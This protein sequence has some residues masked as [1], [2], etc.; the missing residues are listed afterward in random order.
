LF[1]VNG[2]G[3]VDPDVA[4]AAAKK[5]AKPKKLTKDL[6]SYRVRHLK[7]CFRLPVKV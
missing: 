4:S 2:S 1:G 5:L 7:I 6:A 3:N